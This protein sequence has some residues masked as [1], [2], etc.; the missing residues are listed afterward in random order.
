V[1]LCVYVAG[2]MTGYP[3]HNRPAFAAEAARLRALGYRVLSPAEKMGTED[4]EAAIARGSKHLD[5]ADYHRFM[6]EDLLWILTECDAVQ[7]LPGW[8][9]SRG[10]RVER[11]VAE[12]IGLQIWEPG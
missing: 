4:V 11:D 3:E 10:A 6:R 5:S 8:E 12:V 2:P 9:A 7:L 1:S